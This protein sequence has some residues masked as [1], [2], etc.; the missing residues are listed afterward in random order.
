[1]EK[2]K[3]RTNEWN[4]WMNK[5]KKSCSIYRSEVKN[6]NNSGTSRTVA[7]LRYDEKK[8]SNSF[9]PHPT[10][11]TNL[12]YNIWTN[13]ILNYRFWW[14]W[15]WRWRQAMS[16]T[17]IWI[18]YFK[19]NWNASIISIVCPFFWWI[20]FVYPNIQIHTRLTQYVIVYFIFYIVWSEI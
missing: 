19:R 15:R 10:E 16:R 12:C 7:K 20:N 5:Q 6:N 8:N 2:M 1:M 13:V 11:L 9:W 18:E 3:H 17:P 4:E 14:R